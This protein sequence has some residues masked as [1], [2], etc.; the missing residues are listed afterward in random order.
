M[1]WFFAF[2]FPLYLK[3]LAFHTLSYDKKGD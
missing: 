2:R 3:K 1:K